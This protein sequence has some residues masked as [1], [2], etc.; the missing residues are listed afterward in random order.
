VGEQGA[1]VFLHDAVLKIAYQEKGKKRERIKALNS[2][3]LN[4]MCATLRSY[5]QQVFFFKCAVL[6]NTTI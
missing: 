1:G 6:N 2:F 3:R 5:L 4:V